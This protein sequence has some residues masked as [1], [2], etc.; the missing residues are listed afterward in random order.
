MLW[1]PRNRQTEQSF[2]D[3]LFCKFEKPLSKNGR[4]RKNSWYLQYG[5]LIFTAAAGQN[6]QQGSH[7]K[8]FKFKITENKG[9]GQ[10]F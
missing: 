10:I 8:F 4:Y 2:W 3:Q 5:K 1:S 9:E 7:N 6:L